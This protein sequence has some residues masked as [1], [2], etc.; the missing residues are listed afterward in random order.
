MSEIAFLTRL[1]V[2]AI[3]VVIVKAGLL[4]NVKMVKSFLKNLTCGIVMLGL[5]M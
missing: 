4:L 3:L 1:S 2:L 5:R